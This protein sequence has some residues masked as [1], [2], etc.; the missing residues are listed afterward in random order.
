[1]PELAREGLAVPVKRRLSA[2]DAFSGCCEGFSFKPG[3]ERL[4]HEVFLSLDE[5]RPFTGS[6]MG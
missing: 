3:D 5:A 6:Q 1:M 2:T 4:D